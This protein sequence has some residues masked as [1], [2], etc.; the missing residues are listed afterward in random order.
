MFC[1]KRIHCLEK[2]HTTFRVAEVMISIFKLNI[3]KLLI[4][5]LKRCFHL[6]T[7]LNSY[8]DVFVTMDK[9]DWSIR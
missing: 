5:S 7:I 1:Q 3:F 2:F 8:P 6:S 9:Q 4:C